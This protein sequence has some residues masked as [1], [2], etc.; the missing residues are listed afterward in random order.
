MTFMNMWRSV[1]LL[2]IGIG[3]FSFSSAQEAIT[4]APAKAKEQQSFRLPYYFGK[5]GVG[6]AQRDKLIAI[7]QS[8]EEKLAPLRQQIKQLLKERD[9]TMEESLTEGQKLRLKE[10]RAEA[11]AKEAR[12]KKKA[13]AEK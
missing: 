1:L 13:E 8:Y 12:M 2:T 10:L 4:D 9:Q 3:L 5:L 7:N 6:D 11:K